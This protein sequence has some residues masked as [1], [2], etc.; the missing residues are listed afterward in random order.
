MTRA[1][2]D[3]N[4]SASASASPAK[5][6]KWARRSSSIVAAS[7]FIEGNKRCRCVAKGAN[8]VPGAP[9]SRAVVDLCKSSARSWPCATSRAVAEASAS[10]MRWAARFA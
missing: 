7:P 1:R 6:S 5:K 3:G 8:N 9:K 10:R 4:T 2:S